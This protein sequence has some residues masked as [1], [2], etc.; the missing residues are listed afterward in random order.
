MAGATVGSMLA[1]LTETLPMNGFLVFGATGTGLSCDGVGTMH[2]IQGQ[3]DMG[4]AA[5]WCLEKSAIS[6]IVVRE[7]MP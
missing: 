7:F 3:P 4:R 6:V 5:K 1:N 2:N